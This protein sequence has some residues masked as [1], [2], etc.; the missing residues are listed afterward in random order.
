MS[1]LIQKIQAARVDAAERAVLE[2]LA[3]RGL[4]DQETLDLLKDPKDAEI[5][6]LRTSNAELLKVAKEYKAEKVI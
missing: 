1:D 4:A 3:A 2:D 6:R 5:D